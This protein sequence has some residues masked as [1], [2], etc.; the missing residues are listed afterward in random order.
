MAAVGSDLD[1]RE[2]ALDEVGIRI[3][4]FH[5]SSDADLE[6]MGVDRALLPTPDAW[7]AL[8][9]ED[10]AR[11]LNER[12]YYSVLWLV[13]GDPVGFASA[14]PIDFGNEAFMH[15]HIVSEAQRA[16]GLGVEFVKRSVRVFFEA[17]ELE[18]LFCEPNALNVAPNRTVQAAGFRYLFS[19]HTTPGPIN[20]PQVTT[21]WVLDAPPQSASSGQTSS[22]S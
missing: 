18:R 12:H 20:V 11:P 2:M 14:G 4:Y 22:R 5:G 21:R 15:L 17:L 16:S 9:E 13:G 7:R 6:R 19:H 8:Y 1:V 10:Y 3:A